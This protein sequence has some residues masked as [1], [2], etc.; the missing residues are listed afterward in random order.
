MSNPF[1]NGV[2]E[3]AWLTYGP[4]DDPIP[5]N[6]LPDESRAALKE[7]GESWLD[8]VDI[9]ELINKINGGGDPEMLPP[10]AKYADAFD[11]ICVEWLKLTEQFRNI[12][13]NLY[14]ET[15]GDDWRSE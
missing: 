1:S 11:D 3:P 5:D 8:P 10:A 9:K 15:V 2:P 14:D 12:V 13:L 7:L 6:Y 4:G